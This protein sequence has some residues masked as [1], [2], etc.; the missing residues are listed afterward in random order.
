MTIQPAL[1]EQVRQR[2][3][4]ACEFCGVTETDVGS[5]LTID[6]FR[7][8][9]KGGS[10]RLDNLVYC[11]TA[12]NQYKSDYWPATL[13]DPKLWNPRLASSTKHI[14]ELDDGVLHP[15]TPVGVFTVRRLRLNRPPLIACR[16]RKRREAERA[17][18]LRRFE[19]LNPIL[20]AVLFQ[21]AGLKEEQQRLL[22]SLAGTLQRLLEIE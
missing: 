12:C 20:A 8:R 10:D 17:R 15:L 5:E 9:T 21:E 13:E 7:P 1:R 11:C 16:L 6:H 18:V 22:G 19:E 2:A 14:L 3:G 4:F